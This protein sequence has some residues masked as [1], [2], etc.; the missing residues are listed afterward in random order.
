MYDL[1]QLPSFT[2]GVI[3][4][5]LGQASNPWLRRRNA[6]NLFVATTPFCLLV[7]QEQPQQQQQHAN[8]SLEN[9]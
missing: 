1:E 4:V 3:C 2:R 8:V 6:V 9:T 7:F 5:Y